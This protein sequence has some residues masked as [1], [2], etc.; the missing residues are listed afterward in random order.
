MDGNGLCVDSSN[1]IYFQTGNGSFSAN[2]NGGDY[3]DTIVKLSTT[4][5]L[6]VA[7]YF[8]PSDQASLAAGDTDLGSGG[9]MLLPDSMGSAAHPH[10]LVG[11]GKEGTIYLVDRDNMGKY[12]VN[13]DNQ[14]VQE[15]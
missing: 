3:A 14:I 10:L 2:T 9:P 7:D 11:C 1:N 8:T 4:N 6:A 15:L 13:N 5:G 12:N